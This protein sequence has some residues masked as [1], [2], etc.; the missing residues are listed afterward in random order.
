MREDTVN[1]SRIERGG[2]PRRGFEGQRLEPPAPKKKPLIT[3]RPGPSLFWRGRYR[4]GL[5]STVGA[6]GHRETFE[7]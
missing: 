2:F 3:L 1:P 4:T 6:R 7:D 5:G